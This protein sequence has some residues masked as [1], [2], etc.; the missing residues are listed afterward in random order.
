MG[1]QSEPPLHR[2]VIETIAA[3][4]RLYDDTV[5]ESEPPLH[6]EVIETHLVHIHF[7]RHCLSEPPLHREVIET[8]NGSPGTVN[9][10]WSEPPLHREVIET[11]RNYLLSVP[12]D[13][14]LNHPYTA[15]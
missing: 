10:I 11:R 3:S 5:S 14:C 4:W 2:E 12:L 13:F 1:L 8:P 6:R 9:S 7:K 15:R